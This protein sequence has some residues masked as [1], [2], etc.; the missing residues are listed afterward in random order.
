MKKQI[1]FILIVLLIGLCVFLAMHHKTN[2]YFPLVS[3]DVTPDE[4]PR[5]TLNPLEKKV[6]QPMLAMQFVFE[7]QNSKDA[8]ENTVAKLSQMTLNQCTICSVRH[9]QCATQLGPDQQRLL[10]DAPLKDPVGR[11]DNG[12]VA[13]SSSESGVSLLACQQA[14]IQARAQSQRFVCYP[15]QATRN[16]L[17]RLPLTWDQMQLPFWSFWIA[18]LCS[19]FCCWLIIRYEHLHSHLSHDLSD[20][21]PQKMHFHP[22]PRIGGVAII[23]G[24]F[25]GDG[26]LNNWMAAPSNR[27]MNLLILSALPTFFGG[28]IEDLTK[29][30][31]VIERLLI[32]MLS[33]AIAAWLLGLIL[34]RLDVPI[35]DLLLVWLPVAILLTIFAVAGIS[36]AINI[37]DGF[38]GLSA[39]YAIIA[40]TA[41]AWVS[42][43]VADILVFEI[44]LL[45]GAAL[46]GF[47]IWNWPRGGLFLGD[48]G[49]YLVG[50]I[51]AELSII[52]VVRHPEVSA[53]FPVLILAHPIIE[54]VY[55]M[56]RRAL[57]KG[58]SP[59]EPDAYHLHQLLY[60]WVCQRAPTSATVEDSRS[61]NGDYWNNAKVAPYFWLWGLIFAVLGV[62]FFKSTPVMIGAFLSYVII[63]VITYRL[64]KWN[65][66]KIA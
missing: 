9:M 66:K 11:M 16:K 64:L 51:L 43:Y 58:M 7:P 60:Q 4:V 50:F 32:T 8:C 33:G 52:L 14:Q 26:V 31:G 22:T 63:Y 6:S 53:W 40:L 27:E 12:V 49:A 5:V 47:L 48:G 21:G 30:V 29:R 38:N 34:N 1:F 62:Q 2:V 56:F 23:V 18:L 28:F 61:K 15:P 39:G 37:I 59:G 35:L 54:T 55:S 17:E 10:S 44:S 25:V 24:L 36:N 19:V 20:S 3:I 42:F 57:K 41:M 13:F 46:I 45:T 65:S